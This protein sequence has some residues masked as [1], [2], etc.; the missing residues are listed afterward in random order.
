MPSPGYEWNLP[1]ILYTEINCK[2]TLQPSFWRGTLRLLVTVKVPSVP[3]L[4]TLM[5]EAT[6]CSEMSVLT[7]ATRRNIPK[8][9]ILQIFL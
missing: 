6:H 3:I 9:G 4:V 8:D 7:R 2:T 1:L 5:M